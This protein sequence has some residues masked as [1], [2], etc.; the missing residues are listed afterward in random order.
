MKLRQYVL[1]GGLLPVALALANLVPAAV[2]SPGGN[3]ATERPRV[4]DP[5][6]GP[7]PVT[8]TGRDALTDTELD[9]ARAAAVD[10]ALAA[11][12]TDVTGAKGPEFLSSSLVTEPAA[13]N[14]SGAPRRA[15]LFYYD[16]RA[17]K[18]IKQVVDVSSGK[19]LNS[20]S[21]AG[22]QPPASRREVATALDLLLAHGLGRELREGFAKAAGRPFTG[23]DQLVTTAH[24]YRARPADSGAKQCGRHRCLQLVV[25]VSDGPFID[26]NHIVVD[27]SGRTVARLK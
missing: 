7:P 4:S 18:L 14:R 1:A 20:Y 11:A 26:L 22:M 23:A 17:D 16:Y 6:P 15:A 2:P 21:A 13:R 25:Q 5:A 8:G 9:R 10:P 3:P 27:L 24:T 19:V 12:T